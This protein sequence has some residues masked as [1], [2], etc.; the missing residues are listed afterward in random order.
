MQS[1]SLTFP[2]LNLL[3]AVVLAT[4]ASI[5]LGRRTNPLLWA[6]VMVTLVFVYGLPDQQYSMNVDVEVL[7]LTHFLMLAYLLMVMLIARG[8]SGSLNDVIAC[9]TA[10]PSRALVVI[11]LAWLSVRAYLL[12]RHGP[13]ALLFSRAQLEQATGLVEF[14]SFEVAISSITT[15]LLLGAIA[16]VA[17]RHAAGHGVGSRLVTVS[18]LLM[19]VLIIVANE[20]PIGS[21]RLLLVLAALWVAV[22]WAR[23]GLSP[24]AWTWRQRARLA[25]VGLAVALLSVYYQQ[26]RYNDI[27]DLLSADHPIEVI[28]G[29]WKFASTFDQGTSQEDVQFLRSGSLDFF[30]KVVEVALINGKSTGGEATAFSLALAVPKALYPGEKPIGDVD[31]ILESH[32][33]IYPDRPVLNVDY[34]TSLPAI[35]VADFGPVGVVPA[36]LLLGLLFVAAGQAMRSFAF[37][38]YA[39]IVGLGLMIQLIG[40]QEVSLTGVLSA[41]RDACLALLLVMIGS[42]ALRIGSQALRCAVIQRASSSPVNHGQLQR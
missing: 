18:L 1:A 5:L 28:A 42:Y 8:R 35:G 38:P 3:A 23:F 2:A 4:F 41:A 37:G 31:Q 14:A 15:L 33:Q 20:S 39:R 16:L 25:F 29:V 7:A 30:A 6:F 21:R 27:S 34:S 12:V 17:I 19:L 10:I 22:V 11:A 40:S 26:V 9:C 24:R 36:A 32:L 13:A